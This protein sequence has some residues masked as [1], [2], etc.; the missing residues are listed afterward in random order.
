LKRLEGK[1]L[2]KIDKDGV[3]EIHEQLRDMGRMIVETDSMYIGTRWWKI[4][5]ATWSGKVQKV[6]ERIECL[7]FNEPTKESKTHFDITKPLVSLRFLGFQGFEGSISLDKIL[8]QSKNLQCLMVICQPKERLEI[9]SNPFSFEWDNHKYLQILVIEGISTLYDI[10]DS[11]GQLKFL[12]KM[13]IKD[14]KNLQSLP[15]TIGNLGILTYFDLSG[16]ASLKEIPK[17]LGNLN[18]LTSLDLSWCWSLKEIPETLG[19]LTSLTSL[20][21]SGCG[22]L[23]EIPEALGNLTSLTS[24]N[25]YQCWGLKEIPET[26]GNLTSLTTFDLIGCKGLKEIPEALGNLSSLISL[27]LFECCV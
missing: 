9:T 2:I 11:I 5:D 17:G 22:G 26:F 21:L 27:N 15:S 10:S 23:K 14:C 18:S 13:R 6:M 20:D 12:Y 1:S 7:S 8:H 16:C 25:L 19:N 3:Y 24:L 4:Q